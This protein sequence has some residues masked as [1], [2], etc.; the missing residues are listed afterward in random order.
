MYYNTIKY[1]ALIYKLQ[2]KT[3]N[4]YKNFI[5]FNLNLL[6]AIVCIWEAKKAE[7]A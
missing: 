1:I 3:T 4:S 7:N 6:N 2:T 5:Q